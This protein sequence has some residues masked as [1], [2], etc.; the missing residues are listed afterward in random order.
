MAGVKLYPFDLIKLV[1]KE[2]VAIL[3]ESKVV[4][5]QPQHILLAAERVLSSTTKTGALKYKEL[6]TQVYNSVEQFTSSRHT[7]NSTLEEK[8]GIAQNPQLIRIVDMKN[9][10]KKY[11]GKGQRLAKLAPVALASIYFSIFGKIVA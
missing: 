1:A 3:N 7:A 11:L 8:A 10:L 6:K 9:L 4:T 2:S 5:L